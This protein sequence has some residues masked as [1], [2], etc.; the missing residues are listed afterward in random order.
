MYE[1]MGV[2]PAMAVRMDPRTIVRIT[3]TWS[4]SAVVPIAID[5]PDLEQVFWDPQDPVLLWFVDDSNTLVSYDVDT[6]TKTPV[7]AFDCGGRID[8]GDDPMY[9]SWDLDVFGRAADL[10]VG[11]SP[12]QVSAAHVAGAVVVV[13]HR[14]VAI[15]GIRL[16]CTVGAAVRAFDRNR[17]RSGIAARRNVV[18][19]SACRTGVAHGRIVGRGG[20]RGRDQQAQQQQSMWFHVCL[21]VRGR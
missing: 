4:G 3:D 5:P 2:G 21:L 8:G 17:L 15:T 18:G 7:R 13:A 20:T 9:P 12:T 10:R 14:R 1:V 11:H 6:A 19:F 16:P